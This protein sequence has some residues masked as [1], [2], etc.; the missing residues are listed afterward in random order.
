MD[1]KFVNQFM[2]TYVYALTSVLIVHRQQ[3]INLIKD[4]V[5]GCHAV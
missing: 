2:F 1:L 3:I 4:A 5:L